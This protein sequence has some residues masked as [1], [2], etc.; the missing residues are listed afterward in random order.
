M[1]TIDGKSYDLPPGGRQ[2]ISLD[3]GKHSLVVKDVTGKPI[4]DTSF[5]V[6]KA[7][8]VNAAKGEYVIWKTL[9]GMQKNREVLLKEEWVEMDSTEFFGDFELL[10][11]EIP[12]LESNWNYGLDDAFPA[13]QKLMIFSD[14]VVESKVFR[15]IEFKNEYRRIAAP[16]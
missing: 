2:N 8:I 14:F 15:E 1:V 9:Y 11:P 3:Q 7:G 13:A 5:Q 6:N 10:G 16:Q 4:Q 12:F